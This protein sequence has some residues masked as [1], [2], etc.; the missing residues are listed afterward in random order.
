MGDEREWSGE[1]VEISCCGCGADEGVCG[2]V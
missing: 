2:N 1:A